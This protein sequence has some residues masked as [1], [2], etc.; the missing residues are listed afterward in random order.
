MTDEPR[1]PRATHRP[2]RAAPRGKGAAVPDGPLAVLLGAGVF[3]QAHL[4][5]P[6]P[7]SEGVEPDVGGIAFIVDRSRP[8]AASHYNLPPSRFR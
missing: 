1:N 6:G 7:R 3:L 2:R 4:L 8:P 5:S